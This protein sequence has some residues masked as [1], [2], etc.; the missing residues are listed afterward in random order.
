MPSIVGLSLQ[1]IITSVL[2][3]NIQVCYNVERFSIDQQTDIFSVKMHSI[4]N[5]SQVYIVLMR[6]TL[7][8]GSCG[9]G[10]CSS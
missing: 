3:A 6:Y 1:L 10:N 9:S 5:I 8:W 4:N 2:Q 7:K